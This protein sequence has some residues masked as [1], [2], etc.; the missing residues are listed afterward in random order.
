M[1]TAVRIEPEIE[2]SLGDDQLVAFV[3][4]D[5]TRSAVAAA[6]Q[7]R[8]PTALVHDGGLSGAL[9]LLAQEPSPPLLIVDFGGIE[10]PVEGLRSLQ[11]VCQPGTR[12]VA[13][14]DT[15]DITLY[16]TMRS[17]G[18]ASYVLK[19]IDRDLLATALKGSIQTQAATASEMPKKAR[20]MCVV[21]ARGGVGTTTVAVNTAW[22]LAHEHKKSMSIVD[23]D[24][25]FG[26]VAL[27]LDLEPSHGLR[28]ALE[29]PGRIDS[30]FLASAMVHESDNLLVFG[31]EEPLEEE[32]G[33]MSSAFQHLVENLPPELDGIVVDVPP[34][35]AIAR[36]EVL[37]AADTIAIV[38]DLSLAGMR[39]TLRMGHF[40]RAVA[41]HAVTVVVANKVGAARG[42]EIG[43]GDFEK[44]VELPVRHFIPFEPKVVAAAANAGKPLAAINRKSEVVKTI[45]RLAE[46]MAGE[47]PKKK[48]RQIGGLK[49]FLKRA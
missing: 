16:H 5:E 39:D 10:D 24:L 26:T 17:A 49:R 27:S 6:I 43:R 13:L 28:E 33:M 9:A 36:R 45:A 48:A 8:W 7:D 19:P 38:S 20:V 31:A 18:A 30:L 35:I 41:P 32:C 3:N 1:N 22:I 15:N 46:S 12:I 47:R 37:A 2:S 14:G 23:L 25:Q 34:R 21:G 4:D 42:H 11:Q 44:G 40:A 29:H